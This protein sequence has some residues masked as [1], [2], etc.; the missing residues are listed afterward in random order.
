MLNLLQSRIPKRAEL[1]TSEHMSRI[2]ARG[3][4]IQFADGEVIRFRGDVTKV[5]YLVESGQ[6]IAGS[7]GADGS[8]VT[9]ALM[10]PGEH[11]GENTLLAGTPRLQNLCAVGDTELLQY[12]EQAFFQLYNSEPDFGRALLTIGQARWPLKVRVAHLLLSSLGEEQ[13]KH[14]HTVNCRQEDLAEIL[15]VSRVAV[16]KALKTLETDGLARRGYGVIELPDVRQLLDW[17]DS[18]YQLVPIKPMSDWR[19]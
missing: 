2:Y 15:G 12:S 16:S 13:Q 1:L 8:F 17:L 19:F 18:N 3:K 14:S 11:F 10:N 5:F 4:R 9:A 6:V 7:E